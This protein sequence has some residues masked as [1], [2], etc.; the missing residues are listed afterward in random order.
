M[1]EIEVMKSLEACSSGCKCDLCYYGGVQYCDDELMK[2]SL[3]A[4]KHQQAEIEERNKTIEK[5]DAN[6]KILNTAC[7]FKFDK[8]DLF[9]GVNEIIEEAVAH[10][11]DSGGSYNSNWRGILEAMELFL[12]KY[13]K[14]NQLLIVVD[15]GVPKFLEK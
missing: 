10:G 12:G 9:K 5:M 13:D 1:T 4:I 7:K 15:D 11:G 6:I 8:A 3:R 14:E 2:D